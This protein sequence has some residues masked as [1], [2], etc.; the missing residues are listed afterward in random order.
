VKVGDKVLV[1]AEGPHGCGIVQA[2]VTHVYE[3]GGTA[4][5]GVHGYRSC[6]EGIMWTRGHD[7]TTDEAKALL[8]AAA[9]S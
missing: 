3:S 9:L 7:P 5:D 6:D 2:E 4:V 8:T 1:L